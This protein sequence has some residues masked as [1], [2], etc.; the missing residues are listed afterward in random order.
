[1]STSMDLLVL[2]RSKPRCTFL[3]VNRTTQITFH[4]LRSTARSI[5]FLEAHTHWSHTIPLQL[6]NVKGE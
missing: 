6:D 2:H 1:M 5:G 4:P 3:L